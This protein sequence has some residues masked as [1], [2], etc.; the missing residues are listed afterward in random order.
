MPA[1]TACHKCKAPLPG[2]SGDGPAARCPSC[3]EPVPSP[4]AAAAPARDPSLPETIGTY[5]VR[6]ELGR[7]AFGV[8]YRAHDPAL[9][10]EVA[11]K[12]LNR[13]ALSSP[14]AV[15]RFLREAQ[16]V[17]QMHNAHV[18]PVYQLGEQDGAHYIVSKFIEGPVLSSVVE[19]GMDSERAVRLTLD[20]LEALSCAHDDGVIHRDVKPSNAV[21]NGKDQLLLM[22]FGLAGWVG[23][24]A[25]RMTQDGTV[26]GTAAYMAPEQA[27]GDIASVG[28]AA[29]QYSAGV[30]L[31][32]LLTGRVPFEGSKIQVLLYNVIHTPPPP[33][34]S[35]RPVDAELE[36]I[37]L[38]ALAKKPGDRFPDCRAMARALRA[39]QDGNAAP[40]PRAGAAARATA[41][42]TPEARETRV[43]P[44]EA[45]G[46][47]TTVNAEPAKKTALAPLHEEDPDE[48]AFDPAGGPSRRALLWVGAAGLG[49]PLLGGI[50][51]LVTNLVGPKGR[52]GPGLREG[53]ENSSTP[54]G[55][56]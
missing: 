41:A 43:T 6:K 28:P 29:D 8:V 16:V 40:N 13:D 36:D 4:A 22:D 21:L 31:Y 54:K 17:A 27:L 37:V 48:P 47:K 25:G 2:S 38:K 50:A 23:Q 30:V 55:S 53:K 51:Y 56:R 32:E 39:W 12:V 34:S 26:M 14:K 11:I 15:E 45:S 7:G 3:G 1:L 10:R 19:D 20:L 52:G 24:D 46:R 49:L 44:A 33:P 18:V 35:W 9:R 42:Q 5:Q